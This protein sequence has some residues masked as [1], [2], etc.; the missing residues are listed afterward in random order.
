MIPCALEISA[1]NDADDTVASHSGI[2]DLDIASGREPRSDHEVAI[3]GT[4]F[5][6]PFELRV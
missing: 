2:V 6:S 3:T 1:R 4:G 5:G